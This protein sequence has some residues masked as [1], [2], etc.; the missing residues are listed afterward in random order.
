MFGRRLLDAVGLYSAIR[1]IASH[2]FAIR[3]HQINDL[4]KTSSLVKTIKQG[5]KP[6]RSDISVTASIY[7]NGHVSYAANPVVGLD[8][9]HHYRPSSDNSTDDAAPVQD[10]DIKQSAPERDVLPDGTQVVKDKE[11]AS[12]SVNE[13]VYSARP[14]TGLANDVIDNNSRDGNLTIHQERSIS[15]PLP[16]GSFIRKDSGDVGKGNNLERDTSASATVPSKIVDGEDGRTHISSYSKRSKH[17]TSN[18]RDTSNIPLNTTVDDVTSKG[19]NADISSHG[20]GN[21]N[22]QVKITSTDDISDG[23]N[24]D[25]FQSAK[26]GS[27]LHNGNQEDRRQAYIAEMNAFR[28]KNKKEPQI[29][30]AEVKKAPEQEVKIEQ[31]K[32]NES[33]VPSSRL[34]RI[35]QFGGLATSM[36]VG[37]MSESFR[38]ATGSSEGRD[39]SLML[40]ER[41]MNILVSKLSRMRGAALKLGQMM[42]FQDSKLLPPQLNA[43]LQRVQSSAD[44]MPISQRDEVLI[45]N[46]GPD[47]KSKFSSFDDIPIAAASIGQVHKATLSSNNQ[48]VAVKIQYP[49]VATSISSDLSNLSLLLTASRLLPKGLY[50]DRTIANARTELGWECDYIRESECTSRFQSLV[51]ST[52]ALS[53]IF[54]VPHVYS[55]ASGPT[56]LTTSFMAGTPVTRIPDL[57]QSERNH[58]GTSI[59][60]LCFYELMTWRFMQTDPNWT[61][62]LY[63]RSDKK[64]ELLDFGASRDFDR[65]TFVRPYVELLRHAADGHRD[66]V[67][68]KSVELGYL[69]GLEGKEMRDAHVDSVMVL[70]EPFAKNNTQ[71]DKKGEYDFSN[72]TITDRVTAKIG[73]M[74]KERLTPP[75]EETYSLHR[76]LSGAFLLCARLGSVVPARKLFTDALERWDKNT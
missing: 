37:A 18:V 58:I 72:Q 21:Q 42:S 4:I 67:V 2:H 5:N 46:L 27:M 44:Y 43:V 25:I 3:N 63:N 15:R 14:K 70:A 19:I 54:S 7:P 64:I 34:S 76:K 30:D 60:T 35:W 29:T 11:N 10:F 71:L 65:D 53:P 68:T 12:R 51:S 6:S 9:D 17:V 75:P 8:Q 13:D 47:W 22:G 38:R 66:G 24:P 56:I 23:V 20:G 50:L 69:T 49:G 74:V 62:F 16:D 45:S 1:S 26:V 59:L 48:P 28:N 61:N 73:L 40:S 41:N 52:P 57:T 36:A 55:D 33:R 32:L 39:G 31:I